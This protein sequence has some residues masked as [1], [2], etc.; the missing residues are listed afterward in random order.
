LRLL[1]GLLQSRVG[2]SD[3]EIKRMMEAYDGTGGGKVGMTFTGGG[4]GGGGGGAAAAE[5]APA[6][7]HTRTHTRT[8]TFTHTHRLAAAAKT[9]FDLKIASFPADKKIG[10][11]SPPD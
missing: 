5:A 10:V 8:H 2:L 9:H 11:R 4:G 6:G 1:G 7:T 3:E